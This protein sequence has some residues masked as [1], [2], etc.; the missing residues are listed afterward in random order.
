MTNKEKMLEVLELS[1]SF[2]AAADNLVSVELAAN[3]NGV[4]VARMFVSGGDACLYDWE[5]TD[6]PH[7]GVFNEFLKTLDTGLEIKFENYRQYGELLITCDTLIRERRAEKTKPQTDFYN[8]LTDWSAEVSEA[9]MLLK[10]AFRFTERDNITDEQR[11]EL[12]N[13]ITIAH[14]KLTALDEEMTAKGNELAKTL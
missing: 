2:P 6:A 8:C 10:T 7:I 12:D 1:A 5:L 14:D 4:P 11:E 9:V 13:L 3:A